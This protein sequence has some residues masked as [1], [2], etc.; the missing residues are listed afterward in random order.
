VHI[1]YTALV[2]ILCPACYI[3]VWIDYNTIQNFLFFKQKSLFFFFLE[4]L[5]TLTE[6]KWGQSSKPFAQCIPSHMPLNISKELNICRAFSVQ[7]E[8]V[9]MKHQ[10]NTHT[11]RK[12]VQSTWNFKSFQ[13]KLHKTN[14]KIWVESC[15]H[16]FITFF[17]FYS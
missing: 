13:L 16:V 9:L 7:Y 14:L 5:D 1:F 2:H 15:K 4:V 6:L 17:F 3:L 10:F 8:S 12:Q 11:V